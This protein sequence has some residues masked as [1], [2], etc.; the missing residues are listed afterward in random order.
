MSEKHIHMCVTD[1]LIP[2]Y[3]SL[4]KNYV[5]WANSYLV[6]PQNWCIQSN[7]TVGDYQI[8]ATFHYDVIIV[9]SRTHN[10]NKLNS[11]VYVLKNCEYF[12]HIFTLS[13]KRWAFDSLL[14][15]CNYS[16]KIWHYSSW[17][18]E[19]ASLLNTHFPLEFAMFVA[20]PTQHS[21]NYG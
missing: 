1:S 13:I 18:W 5:T 9:S 4:K 11:F 3:A 12:L 20:Q 16:L 6:V 2:F 17:R 7:R 15:C 8:F 14:L 21:Y 19:D 10:C